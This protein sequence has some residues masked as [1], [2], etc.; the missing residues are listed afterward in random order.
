MAQAA[1][2]FGHRRVRASARGSRFGGQ[3][4]GRRRALPSDLLTHPLHAF[5]HGA[6]D[7]DGSLMGRAGCL[8]R[9]FRRLRRFDLM[10]G[11][12]RRRLRWSLGRRRRT[13]RLRRSGLD[14]WRRRR[15]RSGLFAQQP[16]QLFFPIQ[17]APLAGLRPW[18]RLSAAFFPFAPL[19][20]EP[21]GSP[22]KEDEEEKDDQAV[23]TGVHGATRAAGVA[24]PPAGK[25][26]PCL[27]IS[28]N[29]PCWSLRRRERYS[30]ASGCRPGCSG[31]G[32]SP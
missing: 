27:I 16:A 3:G 32:N 28:E 15:R 22:R 13:A 12:G 5:A 1:D 19:A 31:T 10:G 23:E 6:L 7:G 8:K 14:W 25:W 18:A 24:R 29:C 9:N 26:F 30:R 2:Q 11:R 20:L 4:G 21:G 17:S